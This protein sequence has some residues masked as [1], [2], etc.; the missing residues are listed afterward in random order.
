MLQATASTASSSSAAAAAAAPA[1]AGPINKFAVTTSKKV[2][3]TKHYARYMARS[4]ASARM[5][6]DGAFR[7]LI[8][9]LC[10]EAGATVEFCS[11]VTVSRWAT[12][13]AQADFDSVRDVIVSRRDQG[14]KFAFTMD[15]GSTKHTMHTLV[16][17]TA[18]W[19][20]VGWGGMHTAVIGACYSPG[21]HKKPKVRADFF[22]MMGR[23]GLEAEHGASL[24][25]DGGSNMQDITTTNNALLDIPCDAHKISN[26]AK[27][28]LAE[29]ASSNLKIRTL[30][31]MH[32]TI[33]YIIVTIRASPL[34]REY[35]LKLQEDRTDASGRSVAPRMLVLGADHKFLFIDYE[36]SSILELA[37]VVFSVNPKDLYPDGGKRDK[38]RTR[39]EEEVELLKKDLLDIEIVAPILRKMAETVQ[40]L[41]CSSQPRIGYVRQQISQLNAVIAEAAQAAKDGGEKRRS[42]AWIASAFANDVNNEYGPEVL[43]HDLYVLAEGLTPTRALESVLLTDEGECP[44][45]EVKRLLFAE[46]ARE[47]EGA[48]EVHEPAGAGA[49]ASSGSAPRPKVSSGSGMAALAVLAKQRA[50]ASDKKPA[51]KAARTAKYEEEWALYLKELD[52]IIESLA[53]GG[54]SVEQ[55][56]LAMWGKLCKKLPRMD[57]TARRLLAIQPTQTASERV[58]SRVKIVTAGRER[59]GKG[60]IELFSMSASN[61]RSL[62]EKFP[63]FRPPPVPLEDD[64][65]EDR[66]SSEDDEPSK[67]PPSSSEDESYASVSAHGAARKRRRS[68]SPPRAAAADSDA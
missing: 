58:F 8:T 28:V 62:E 49:G 7:Q 4:G 26:I 41:S 19:I 29:T 14:V 33:H 15:Y 6:E 13:I 65:E 23:M 52:K 64:P 2:L 45:S 35:F 34:R 43:D 3:I 47:D 27:H 67:W 38:G 46:W 9:D 21:K 61:V 39:W 66:G 60:N 5:V 68:Q 31:D 40:F 63:S 53:S 36:F 10:A 17:A 24:T 32:D 55:S 44:L 25:H 12:K 54:S 1:T 37:D 30:K 56:D 51:G 57:V 48:D 20:E 50:A 42:A 18:T 22:K 11:R 16:G 59:L